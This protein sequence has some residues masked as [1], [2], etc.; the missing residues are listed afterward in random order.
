MFGSPTEGRTPRPSTVTGEQP[1]ARETGEQSLDPE[2]LAI[3]PVDVTAEAFPLRPEGENKATLRILLPTGDVFDKELV[4]A[5]AQMGKG[6]R[7]DIVIADPAVSTTHALIKAEKDGYML[8]DLGS[9]NGT[10]LN[11]E[12]ITEPRRL[13]HGDVIGLGLSRLTFRLNDYSETGAIQKDEMNALPSRSTPPPLTEDSLA[14]A[15]SAEG[16][17][18]SGEV[19]RLREEKA[20]RRLYRALIETRAIAEEKLRDLMS[21]IF[22]IPVVD[23]ASA[24]MDEALATRFPARLARARQIFP[25]AVESNRLALAVA[26]PTDTDAVDE[27]KRELDMPVDVRLATASEITYQIERHYSPKLIGVLPTGDKLEYQITHLETEIGKAAHNH[28]VLADQTV[29]NTHA[30]V[31][32]RDGAYSIVD[33]G[34]RNGTYLNGER[35]GTHAQVLRHGDAIQLGKTVLTFRN[36][37]ETAEN[38]TAVLSEETVNEI[39]RRADK[40]PGPK[41]SASTAPSPIPDAAAPRPTPGTSKDQPGISNE[42]APEAPPVVIP[43]TASA[44]DTQHEEEKKKKKKKKKVEEERI[45]AAYIRAIG[46]VVG[47]LLGAAVTVVL[48]ILFI[49]YQNAAPTKPHLTGG[50]ANTSTESPAPARKSRVSIAPNAIAQLPGGTFEASGVIQVP[51]SDAVLFIDDGSPKKV[52]HMTVDGEGRAGEIKEVPLDINIHDPEGITYGGGYFYIIGSQSDPAG[53]KRNGLARFA[54]DPASQTV[55]GQPEVIEDLRSFLIEN[56]PAL[57]GAGEPPGSEGG[58]NIEGIAW[59]PTHESL[60]L[61]LRSPLVDEQALLVPLRLRDPRGPFSREN[62]IVREAQPIRLSLG[63]LGIRDIHYDTRLKSFLIISGATEIQKK[64]DF[65]LWVWAGDTDPANAGTT[66]G[67]EATLDRDMKPEGVAHMRVGGKDFIFIVGDASRYLKADY[68][69]GQ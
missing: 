18:P 51:N 36:P 2:T 11:G 37:E 28:I 32:A 41:A 13:S 50:P 45:R 31:L 43:A 39:R 17:I 19:A 20:G 6:P 52:F 68:A 59:D 10:H 54:F 21:R 44:L 27:V 33:L 46:T 55:Q 5:E 62:L 9:R 23:L 8:T 15:L 1:V 47:P 56:V 7:N 38:I 66:P 58:L 25:I 64:T 3:D 63:G 40:E 49:R 57:K 30:V 29:S 65:K 53:G 4:N 24:D 26:D 48:S 60:L 14:Q 69:A 61:G 16:L 42:P 35:L 22:K 34:S 67:E 12:R